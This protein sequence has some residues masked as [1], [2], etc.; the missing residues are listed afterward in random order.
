MA[1][2]NRTKES[3]NPQRQQLKMDRVTRKNEI[4]TFLREAFRVKLSKLLKGLTSQAVKRKVFCK[5]AW[6]WK[7]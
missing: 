1:F 3:Q 7:S 6:Q 5:P 4:K 2:E